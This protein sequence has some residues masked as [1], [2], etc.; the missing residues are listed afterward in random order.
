[1]I[2]GI[3]VVISNTHTHHTH[4]RHNLPTKTNTK[5]ENEEDNE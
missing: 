4:I 3:Q 1:M 2:Y 5:S